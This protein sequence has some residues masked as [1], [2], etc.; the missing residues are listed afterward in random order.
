MFKDLDYLGSSARNGTRVSNQ[1]KAGDRQFNKLI[2]MHLDIQNNGLII[3]NY[4]IV[5]RWYY[6]IKQK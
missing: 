3:L 6:K 5:E 1:D 2:S 4:Q